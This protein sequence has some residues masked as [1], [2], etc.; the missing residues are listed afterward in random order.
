VGVVGPF[1][2][3][4][5]QLLGSPVG[6]AS[7]ALTISPISLDG[8][9]ADVMRSTAAEF[10]VG[11]RGNGPYS[12][13]AKGVLPVLKHVY[14]I[15]SDRNDSIA[16][17]YHV[18]AVRNYTLEQ[19]L[20]DY[21][22]N[23][24]HVVLMVLATIVLAVSV[25]RGNRILRRALLL[26]VT[27]GAGYLLFSGL[28]RWNPFGVRLILPLLV[29]W[30]AIIAIALDRLPRWV[31]RLV[32]LG[33]LI[34]CVPQ[35]VDNA[36]APLIPAQISHEPYLTPYFFDSHTV[37]P[38]P[39]EA[40]HY[41]SITAMLAQSACT[42]ASIGNWVQME[43]P[44]WVGLAHNH[45]GGSSTTSTWTMSPVASSRGIAHAR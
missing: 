43:Y 20:G 11:D 44:L 29:A 30:S 28:Y 22:A 42:Q 13:L 35:L 12:Y 36:S 31:G 15:F 45:W 19:R 37:T 26:A 9:G 39:V 24:W 38:P 27:L 34:A 6:P 5:I 1:M 33:L 25:L 4:N 14:S 18:F 23:P 40:S 2:T 41:G 17:D 7:K 16:R 8:M 10:D 32:L 21:G 3:Q